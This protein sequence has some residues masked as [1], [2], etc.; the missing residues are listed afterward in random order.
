[1]LYH[2]K[3]IYNTMIMY[4]VYGKLFK[5]KQEVQSS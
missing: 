2:V 5:Q 1:M 4:D 3:N